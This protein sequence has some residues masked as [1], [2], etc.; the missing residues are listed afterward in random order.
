MAEQYVGLE[1]IDDGIWQVYFGHVELC[2]FH[3]RD[4][5]IEDSLGR[6]APQKQ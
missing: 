4:G 6:K 2:R 1:T 3:E 5:K